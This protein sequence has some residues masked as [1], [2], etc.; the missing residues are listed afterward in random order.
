[1]LLN[2]N[3]NEMNSKTSLN[4]EISLP[5]IGNNGSAAVLEKM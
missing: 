2:R 1:M 5:T 4:I 3:Q